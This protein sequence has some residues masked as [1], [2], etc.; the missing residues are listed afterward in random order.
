MSITLNLKLTDLLHF[1]K[2]SS[3]FSHL[4]QNFLR[5]VTVNLA[6][7]ATAVPPKGADVGDRRFVR[8]QYRY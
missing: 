4:L 6:A 5:F 8:H 7:I 1:V 3:H 2:R